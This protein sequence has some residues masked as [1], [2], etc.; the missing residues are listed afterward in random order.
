MLPPV[1]VWSRAEMMQR[2]A[3]F[4]DLKRFRDGLQDVNSPV[5]QQASANAAIKISEGCTTTTPTRRSW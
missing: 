5:G 1:R 4:K 3:R 2:V